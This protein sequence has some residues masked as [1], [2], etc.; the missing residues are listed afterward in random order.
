MID[1]VIKDRE[2]DVVEEVDVDDV[3]VAVFVVVVDN[4]NGDDRY[5]G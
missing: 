3:L 1:S 4:D 2:R 5:E